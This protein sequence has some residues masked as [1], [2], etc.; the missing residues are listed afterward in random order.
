LNA[1]NGIALNVKNSPEVCLDAYRVNRLAVGGGEFVDFTGAKPRV[2]RVF[3]EDLEGGFGGSLLGWQQ[4]GQCAA[5]RFCRP[6]PA[7][8]SA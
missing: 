8:H 7:V 5:E 2:K 1:P 3:F 6:E 4:L